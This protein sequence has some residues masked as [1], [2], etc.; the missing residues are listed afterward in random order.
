MP[1]GTP[2]SGDALKPRKRSVGWNR[3]VVVP[4]SV[5]APSRSFSASAIEDAPRAESSLASITEIAAAT[6][7]RL[8]P[9]PGSG[10]TP[11]TST[12]SANAARASIMSRTRRSP[13]VTRT[14]SRCCGSKPPSV[15]VTV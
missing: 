15:K 11:T 1:C 8:T 6:R 12:C 5:T 13:A 9:T 3:L 14:S 7:S 10:V 4:S 2:I